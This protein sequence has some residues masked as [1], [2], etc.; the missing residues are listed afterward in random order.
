MRSALCDAFPT[1]RELGRLLNDHFGKNIDEIAGHDGNLLDT[2]DD[3]IRWFSAR[4][5]IADLVQA[6]FTERPGARRI[7]KMAQQ[8]GRAPTLPENEH[9]ERIL[10]QA[11]H[12]IDPEIWFS[13]FRDVINQIC[14]V[15]VKLR[16][17]ETAFGSGVLIAP[18]IILTNYH[19]I[20]GVAE[21]ARFQQNG[22]DAAPSDIV[23]RFDH[24]KGRPGYIQPGVEFRLE[25]DWLLDSSPYQAEDVQAQNDWSHSAA[26]GLDYALL[27]VAGQ[28]GMQN[29][30]T[31]PAGNAQIQRG[32]IQLGQ[33]SKNCTDGMGLIVAQYPQGG[34]L[35][36]AIETDA[37]T[38]LNSSKNRVKHRV[39][40]EKGSSGAPCF[41][42]DWDL[43]AIH[44]AGIPPTDSAPGYN[45]AVPISSIIANL[46][47][48]GKAHSLGL[49]PQE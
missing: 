42:L 41:T 38:G 32:W 10:R 44:Q 35:K 45:I 8:W 37:V 2:A 3:L 39:N 14:Q 5:K 47:G 7:Q 49:I 4:D 9:L 34:A 13:R 1:R 11:N 33:Q 12:F 31:D 15:E 36:V 28:P 20:E 23:V 21:P 17:G 27:R 19:V 16:S 29:L 48:N 25:Q 43:A 46:K 6:A 22:H 18:D 26:H 30:A 40:T 24:K